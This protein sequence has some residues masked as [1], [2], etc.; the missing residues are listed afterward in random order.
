MTRKALIIYCDN[1]QSGKLSGPSHDFENYQNYLKSHL[2]GKWF[3]EEIIELHNPTRID[4]ALEIFT[5][6]EGCD[7]T[8]IIFTG[9]GC[10]NENNKQCMEVADGDIMIKDIKTNAKRQTIIIDACR[11]REILSNIEPEPRLFSEAM[12]ILLNV[13]STRA[14]FN[15][16]VQKA[17]EGLTILY[18]AS[19]NQSSVDTKYGA[20][21]LISLIK[22]AEN[23][24]DSD[25]SNRI[26]SLKEVHNLAIEYISEN[27][28]TIQNPEMQLE[29]RHTYFPFA[30]K[31]PPL[32]D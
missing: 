9:H 15:N 26:L 30:I 18:A 7:Y 31:V 3:D 13:A 4:I 29:K 24:R 32:N 23:W 14:A 27:F 5:S 19:Q 2:G 20:A 28:E 1:T 21:Y 22:V 8:F 25:N 11:E 10:I 6:M 17:P 12:E 16:A